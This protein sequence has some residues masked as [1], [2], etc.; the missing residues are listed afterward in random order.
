MR[1]NFKPDSYKAGG[2]NQQLQTQPLSENDLTEILMMHQLRVGWQSLFDGMAND[3]AAG[4]SFG[5]EE[6]FVSS[7]LQEAFLAV[8]QWFSK[9][10]M[11]YSLPAGKEYIWEVDF[12]Q[13]QVVCKKNNKVYQNQSNTDNSFVHSH[14]Q[15][16]PVMA[17][18][19]LDT[20]IIQRLYEKKNAIGDLV[21][22]HLRQ[23]LDKAITLNKLEESI[24]CL[25]EAQMDVDNWFL[26]M[27]GIYQWSSGNDHPASLRVDF[28]QKQ[29]Y[30]DQVVTALS[31]KKNNLLCTEE[32]DVVAL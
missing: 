18:T 21:H 27:S 16:L 3:K 6:S 5:N 31:N 25:G 24:R 2:V 12:K 30:M 19:E 32:N 7:Q 15:T 11:K 8:S 9:M 14:I 13:G 1:S 28:R 4:F 20:E 23:Y 22:M 26:E 10:T 29:V 17:L